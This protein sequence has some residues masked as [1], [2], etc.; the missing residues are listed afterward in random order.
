MTQADLSARPFDVIG[1]GVNALDL[2][3]IIDGYPESESNP[4]YA[5]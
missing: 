5:C 4:R 2:I 1:F 3:G